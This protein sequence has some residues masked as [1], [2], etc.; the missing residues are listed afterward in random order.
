MYAY[1]YQRRKRGYETYCHIWKGSKTSAGYGQL[2]R[3]GRPIYAHRAAWEDVN[4]PLGDLTL[5]HLCEQR[6]CVNVE[7]LRAIA[8]AEHNGGEGH[9]KL[10]RSDADQIRRRVSDGETQKAI[11]DEYGVRPSLVSMIVSGKRWK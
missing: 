10:G 9:G 4:G 8:R 6:D 1:Q 2:T 5:H 3:L 11:A 7:H